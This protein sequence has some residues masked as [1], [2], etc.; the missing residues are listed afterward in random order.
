MAWDFGERNAHPPKPCEGNGCNR[1]HWGGNPSG[2]RQVRFQAVQEQVRCQSPAKNIC[3]PKLVKEQKLENDEREGKEPR[4]SSL[5]SSYAQLGAGVCRAA[6]ECS[7]GD[8]YP[9]A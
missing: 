3:I 9:G 8:R 2:Y 1:T 7:Q 6:L 4:R 5:P